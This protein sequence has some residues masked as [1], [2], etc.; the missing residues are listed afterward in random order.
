MEGEAMQEEV[1]YSSRPVRRVP[2]AVLVA[3]QATDGAF[4]SSI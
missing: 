4:N 3:E 2:L 1:I